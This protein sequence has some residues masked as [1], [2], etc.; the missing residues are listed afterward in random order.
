MAYTSKNIDKI[1]EYFKNG[2]K[3][4]ALKLGFEAEH[5]ICSP[6]G[7]SA[8]YETVCYIARELQAECNEAVDI[9]Y[10]G[11]YSG[12]ICDAYSVS[13]EPSCQFEIS[14]FPGEN[15]FGLIGIYSGF[16]DRLSTAAEKLGFS[17]Y[18]LGYHPFARANEL[19]LIPKERYRL[20]DRYFE[21]SGL[22]GRN[23]MRATS[24]VQVSV[25]YTSEEDFIKK[26]RLGAVLSPIL[27]LVCDNSPIFEGKEN[28][29]YAVR[30]YIWSNVDDVRCG[31]IKCIFD[32]DF[33]FRKYAEYIYNTAVIV[34]EQEGK[35]VYAE[36]KSYADIYGGCELREGQVA[37]LLSMFFFDVRLKSYIEIRMADSMPQE[38]ILAYV[39]LIWCIFYGG[40]GECAE[41]LYNKY[42]GVRAEDII[43]AKNEIV[44]NGYSAEV[45]SKT[46]YEILADIFETAMSYADSETFEA[47]KPLYN[48]VKLK[49]TVKEIR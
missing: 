2:I 6:D 46:A 13:F 18:V 22:M 42:C 30:N 23:M 1:V 34:D 33:G 19:P 16:F 29:L 43:S 26:Y 31:V 5:F 24:S 21:K 38:Y 7:K 12:F 44:K 41:Q 17:V 25:D 27:S 11:C 48:A 45:Y 35:T 37:H 8:D 9:L 4:E 39:A 14:I 32:D 15:I 40:K 10:N 20:M 36:N 3:N 49:K 28:D 47:I